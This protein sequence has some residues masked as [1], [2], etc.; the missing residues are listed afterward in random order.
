AVSA[1]LQRIDA[2][3]KLLAA[4]PARSRREAA[5]AAG[6]ALICLSIAGLLW[7]LRLPR[8]HV[9]LDIASDTVAFQLTAPWEI[10]PPLEA[11]QVRIENLE[12][13]RAPA[14]QVDI[15]GGGGN[16]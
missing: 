1:G 4:M 15:D 13:I 10:D 6:V 12:S 16:A 3:Q 2:C 14:L 5:R 8:V 11:S 7:Y 9:T